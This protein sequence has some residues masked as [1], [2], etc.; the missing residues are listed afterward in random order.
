MS[1]LFTRIDPP[2]LQEQPPPLLFGVPQNPDEHSPG[3]GSAEAAA[4]A[5]TRAPSAANIPI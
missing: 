4:G 1:V 2:Q 5:S 3:F